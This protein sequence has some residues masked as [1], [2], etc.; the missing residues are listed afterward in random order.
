MDSHHRHGAMASTRGAQGKA[1]EVT[2]VSTFKESMTLHDPRF[3]DIVPEAWWN[4]PTAVM[5]TL[6]P[7]V[8]FQQQVKP[9]AY[10]LTSPAARPRCR[11]SRANRGR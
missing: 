6:F 3:L 10:C 1:S 8:I 2:Q 4:G 11:N 5:T 7:S 9:C